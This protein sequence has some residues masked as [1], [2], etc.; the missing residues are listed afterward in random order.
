MIVKYIA[1]IVPG[2][3]AESVE[4][5]S[6]Q[7]SLEGIPLLRFLKC[8]SQMGVSEEDLKRKGAVTTIAELLRNVEE[9]LTSHTDQDQNKHWYKL[10]YN[11][12]AYILRELP[13]GSLSKVQ[14]DEMISY[15]I[16]VVLERDLHLHDSI[17]PLFEDYETKQVR[18]ASTSWLRNKFKSNAVRQ[19]YDEEVASLLIKLYNC[20]SLS[21]ELSALFKKCIS[22][23]KVEAFRTKK[24]AEE[25]RTNT[26]A[27]LVRILRIELDKDEMPATMVYNNAEIS[28]IMNLKYDGV[29]P[30]LAAVNALYDDAVKNVI[31][32]WFDKSVSLEADE[33]ICE[34]L[35]KITDKIND[36]S[37]LE[38]AAGLLLNQIRQGSSLSESIEE[39][40]QEIFVQLIRNQFDTSEEAV[41]LRA[42]VQRKSLTKLLDEWA[43]GTIVTC[44]A[45]TAV[46]SMVGTVLNET[47]EKLKMY[48]YPRVYLLR[49]IEALEAFLTQ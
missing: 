18:I 15:I 36:A 47:I 46:G 21:D 44:S 25:F 11:D 35:R 17:L 16:K 1:S 12:L 32:A 27:R 31:D 49:R 34:A 4:F 6:S 14:R 8:M 2:K 40:V 20:G 3:E 23:T 7:P 10:Y 48:G 28:S 19:H 45:R 37:Y 22:D 30:K 42:E 33:E 26:L 24:M 41:T 43:D 39:E 38:D 29:F 13:N 5:I 9:L